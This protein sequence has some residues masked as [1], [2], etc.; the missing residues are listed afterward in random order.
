MSYL[1]SCQNCGEYRVTKKTFLRFLTPILRR[2]LENGSEGKRGR[3][4]VILEFSRFCPRCQPEG[5]TVGILK[6]KRRR[7]S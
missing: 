2:R 4:E 7:P 6:V 5:Q 3:K 1:F